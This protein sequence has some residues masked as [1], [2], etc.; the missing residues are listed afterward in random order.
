MRLSQKGN[1]FFAIV[2]ISIVGLAV[3]L[4]WRN[5][6]GH[7]YSIEW[8]L[9]SYSDWLTNYSAGFVRRGLAGELIA[10][11]ANGRSGAP[12]TNILV[13]G[14]FTG[15][16]IF[17][18]WLA[19]L[20]TG[21]VAPAILL[22]VLMPAG[23]FDMA[24]EN[25]FYYRKEILFL[26]ILEVACLL[27]IGIRHV[28]SRLPK[29]LLIGVLVTFV[30][31]SA[32]LLPLI[33]EGYV[34]LGAPAVFI[35]LA[36]LRRDNPQKIYLKYLL[37]AYPFFPI[38]GFILLSYFKGDKDAA[39]VIW[40]CLPETD[41]LMMHP[42]APSIPSGQIMA[43]GY[44]ILNGIAHSANVILSGAFWFWAFIGICVC[45]I[46]ALITVLLF[47]DAKTAASTFILLPVL[48]VV[49]LPIYIVSSDW[50]RDIANISLAYLLLAYAIKGT[51]S[52]V[53]IKVLRPAT[54]QLV[55]LMNAIASHQRTLFSLAVLFCL[56]FS[57][58]ECCLGVGSESNPFQ[59]VYSRIQKLYHD[60]T[61]GA[62]WVYAAN[63]NVRC[64]Q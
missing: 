20:A 32:T 44:T 5:T 28:K 9:W 56:T 41:R 39:L 47:K 36:M 10:W 55:P 16:S 61:P 3:F 37:W 30:F 27:L 26:V 8:N 13:F 46:L 62:S 63:T 12:V 6:V 31:A 57:Y 19:F 38:G 42:G 33:H 40:S 43:T 14:I 4:V 1:A 64:K 53:E 34:F 58:P 7:L 11:L 2:A 18:L 22:S 48:F 45:S 51:N 21:M 25:Q 52:V 35:L 50:G 24:R 49:S 15:F 54:N 60:V 17:F 23:I 29:N 59:F